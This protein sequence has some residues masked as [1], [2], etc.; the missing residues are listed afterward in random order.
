MMFILREHV[1][2]AEEV[3][4]CYLSLGMDNVETPRATVEQAST[5]TGDEP[6]G[7]CLQQS[8]QTFN[9][10]DVISQ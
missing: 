3:I 2:F 8:T 7:G 1:H 9:T 4:S 6:N 5:H 10:H